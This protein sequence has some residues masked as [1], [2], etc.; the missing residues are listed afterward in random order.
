ML[1]Y[2]LDIMAALKDNGY[3]RTR[4]RK[5]CLL[6]ESAMQHLKRD[7][8]IGPVTLDRICTL[9]GMSP[10]DL[11]GWKPAADTEEPVESEDPWMEALKELEA[12]KE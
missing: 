12:G 2:K 10:G 8:M 4:L 1:Y 11:L 3:S 6:G 7:E 5:E 9:L